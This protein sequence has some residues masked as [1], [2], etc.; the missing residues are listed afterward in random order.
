LAI[1]LGIGVD[2]YFFCGND[3]DFSKVNGTALLLRFDIGYAL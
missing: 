2:N 3:E 1:K